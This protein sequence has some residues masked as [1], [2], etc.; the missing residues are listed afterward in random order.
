M[1]VYENVWNEFITYVTLGN[2]N[3]GFMKRN[4]KIF[5]TEF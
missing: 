3:K 4:K 2:M 1:Y 5:L